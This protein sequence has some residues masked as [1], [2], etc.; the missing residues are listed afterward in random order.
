M[1]HRHHFLYASNGPSVGQW[2]LAHGA[3]GRLIAGAIRLND[4]DD[5]LGR[6][7]A[8]EVVELR[9]SSTYDA[10][11]LLDKLHTALQS[12]HLAAVPVARLI[13]DAGATV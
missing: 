7:R 2:W 3:G 12:N 1:G 10:L 8:G 9:I 13:R 11:P 5:T 6:L 4:N